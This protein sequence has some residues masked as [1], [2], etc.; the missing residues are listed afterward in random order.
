MVGVD[1]PDRLVCSKIKEG[2]S[3]K[4]EI[5]DFIETSYLQAACYTSTAG[6]TYG[7]RMSS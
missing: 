6:A 3:A 4:S 7:P 1:R 2:I 5:K